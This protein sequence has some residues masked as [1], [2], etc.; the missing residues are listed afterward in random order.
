VWAV[1]VIAGEGDIVTS[2]RNFANVFD[3]HK[4]RMIELQCG[5]E[6]C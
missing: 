2:S 3:T 5:E 6:I 4:T 1:S